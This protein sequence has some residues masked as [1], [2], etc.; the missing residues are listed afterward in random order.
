VFV[1]FDFDASLFYIEPF[2]SG[3]RTGLFARTVARNVAEM[4]GSARKYTPAPMATS[5]RT[6]ETTKLVDTGTQATL[7]VH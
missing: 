4:S 2:N 6:I 3:T 5:V 1:Y 7:G